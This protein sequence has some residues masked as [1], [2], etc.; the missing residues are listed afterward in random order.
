MSGPLHGVKVLDLTSVVMGPYATQILGEYGADVIKVEPPEGDIQRLN[1]PMRH[2]RMGAIF[3]TTNR[4]KRSI[5]IDLKKSAGRDLLLKLAGSAD[6]LV[7]NLRPQAM[8]RLDLTYEAVRA[9]NPRIIYIGAFG[10][11]QRGPYASRP[12]Y[13]DLIQGM[14]GIP[15]LTQRA[16]ADVPRY[17]PMILADRTVGLQLATAIVSALFHRERTG[18]GQRVDVPMFE[19]LLSIVLGEHLS[20]T[21]FRPPQGPTGYQ[22]SL[23]HDRR[24]YRTSD[25]HICAM[26]YNDKHWRAFLSAIGE[27][28]RFTDDARF[29]SQGMRLQHI[30]EVYAYLAGILT[31]R[32]TAEW[33]DL[34]ER[35]DIPAAPMY[36]IDDIVTDEHVVGTGF[37]KEV[38]HPSEG[39]MLATAIPTE[40]SA[41]LPDEPS[42]APR[43][44]EHSTDILLEAGFS[45]E[46]IDAMLVDGIV[47][48]T[49]PA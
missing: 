4:G 13:D 15:W 35:A 28:A 3:L 49:S 31:T 30:D 12:A 6:V 47:A 14:C 40:W 25:G 39:P 33:M 10:F 20:G 17:A 37:V 24:P 44:G 36:S 43:L 9:V 2:P 23:S 46:Q 29:S 8:A 26:V 19:G 38:M 32:T 18:V 42:S 45:R 21:L 16:G 7:Y 48:V 11:S 5:V 34:F 41:S 1:G 22:R 27:P